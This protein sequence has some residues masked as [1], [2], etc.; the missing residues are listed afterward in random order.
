MRTLIAC[1]FSM[2]TAV[3]AA[4]EWA[5]GLPVG[6]PFPTVEASDQTGVEGDFDSLKGRNGLLF[7]FN[8]SSDW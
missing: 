2:L 6:T 4:D 7:L 3:A 8:R 5:A 1:V